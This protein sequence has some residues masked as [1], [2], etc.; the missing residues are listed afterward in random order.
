MKKVIVFASVSGLAS[1]AAGQSASLMIVPS[2]ATW[3][4]TVSTVYT[5]SVYAT[6]DFGTHI[7]GGEFA[8]SGF[9]DASTRAGVLSMDASA[10]AWG[11]GFENDRGYAGNADHDGLVFG[12]LIF[13]PVLQPSPDSELANGP[14]LLGSIEVTIAPDTGGLLGWDTAAGQGSFI[15]EIYD[16]VSGSF[17]QVT[18]VNHGSVTVMIPAPAGVG[19]LGFAGL[20]GLRRRR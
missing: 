11:S 6:A 18:S 20:I 5:L 14:V 12:Q 4:S 15:L 10:A 1:M 7:A 19:V 8:L 16:E 2:V 9:G 13:P 17:T 3:D